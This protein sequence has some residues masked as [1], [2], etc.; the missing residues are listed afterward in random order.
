MTKRGS[1]NWKA[2]AEAAAARRAE[3]GITREELIERMGDAAIGAEALR[4][5]EANLQPSYRR[6][7]LAAISIALDW[8]SGE[9]WAIAHGD[10]LTPRDQAAVEELRGELAELRRTLQRVVTHLGLD[11]PDAQARPR[12]PKPK[13]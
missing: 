7:T 5:F 4:R 12:A 6:A 2:A 11:P 13:R 9:L 8:P 3:L 10:E 1:P